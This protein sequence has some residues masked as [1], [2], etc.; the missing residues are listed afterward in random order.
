VPGN[1]VDG[2]EAVSAGMTEER[3]AEVFL[4]EEQAGLGQWVKFS[5]S[6]TAARVAGNRSARR[7]AVLQ[8]F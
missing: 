1:V 4:P 2:A 3:A 7:F 8:I 5:N 6:L